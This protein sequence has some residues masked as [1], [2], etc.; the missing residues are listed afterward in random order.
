MMPP[1]IVPRALVSLGIMITRIAGCS[2]PEAWPL[3]RFVSVIPF[4]P[5]SS[6]PPSGAGSPGRAGL[7]AILAKQVSTDGGNGSYLSSAQFPGGPGGCGAGAARLGTAAGRPGRA[8]RPL[9]PRPARARPAHPRQ[10]RR[11]RGGPAGGLHPGLEPRRALRF[12]PLLG[13][14]LAGAD[15]AQPR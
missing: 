8:V 3:A 7:H 13:L 5:Q 12:R 1:K 6:L 15:R 4:A 14:D 9:R 10:P 2:G 11:R